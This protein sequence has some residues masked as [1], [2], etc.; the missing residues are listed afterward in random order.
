MHKTCTQKQNDRWE[1][2]SKQAFSSEK[3]P[4]GQGATS[5]GK[6]EVTASPFPTR[7]VFPCRNS[8]FS[9]DQ[10]TVQSVHC[11]FNVSDGY[12]SFLKVLFGCVCFFFYNLLGLFH[13]VCFFLMVLILVTSLIF[14]STLILSLLFSSSLI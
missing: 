9:W 12:F 13:R 8:V 5:K 1:T 2:N 6:M 3:Q 4:D 14:L 7:S 10:S 11:V